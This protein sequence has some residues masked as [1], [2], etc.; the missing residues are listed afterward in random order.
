MGVYYCC[1]YHGSLVKKFNSS[2]Q[3][4]RNYSAA[5]QDMFVLTM[6]NGKK[7]GCFI[8]IGAEDAVNENNTYLLESQFNWK[9][10]SID[11]KESSRDSFV[12]H[13]RSACFVWSDALAIDY[14]KMF[15]DFGLNKQIDY[16]SLD[17][18]PASQTLDCLKK[19]PLDDYRFSVITYET[20][21]YNKSYGEENA[22][23]VKKESREILCSYGYELIIGNVFQFE[24]WYVDPY[25][26]DKELIRVM[27]RSS[28]YNLHPLVYLLHCNYN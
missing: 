28:E 3:I 1:D 27:K 9:G 5:L 4:K 11:I 8:E 17:I 10:V 7:N 2:D 26:I 23:R 15:L 13:K 24:D 16:L 21:F 14:K 12:F 22:E 19:L 6:L 25:V 20:D 18:D